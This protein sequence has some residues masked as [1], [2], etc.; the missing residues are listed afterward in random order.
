MVSMADIAEFVDSR[1]GV[2]MSYRVGTSDEKVLAHSFRNDIFLPEIP[3]YRPRSTDTIVDV[4]AHI[5]T[6]TCLMAGLAK[7]GRIVAVEA[8]GDTFA[9]LEKNVSRNSFPNVTAFRS[10]LMDR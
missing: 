2:V 9:L 6:F 3:E 5:G 7:Q 8:C 1:S 10:L 4:G